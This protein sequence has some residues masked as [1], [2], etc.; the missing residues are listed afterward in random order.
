MPKLAINL[1]LDRS[2]VT[3]EPFLIAHELPREVGE[4]ARTVAQYRA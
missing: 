3:I 2:R 4:G 1:D